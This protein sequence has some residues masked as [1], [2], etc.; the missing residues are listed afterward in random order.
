VFR[1]YMR[2]DNPKL[3]EFTYR[4]QFLEAIP[5]KP[6][7]REDSVQASIED[8]RGTIAKL[9][10]MKVNDFVDGSLIRELDQE[11]F[12]ARVEKP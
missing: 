5:A 1:K 11:G 2:V 9:E 3:L 7:P 8:L 4:V 12:F 10:T 6:Y